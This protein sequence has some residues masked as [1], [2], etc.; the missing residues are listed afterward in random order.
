MLTSCDPSRQ[1]KC[2]KTFIL[3]E[4]IKNVVKDLALAY[5]T[6]KLN[7]VFLTRCL[8]TFREPDAFRNR[9][10]MIRTVTP[11]TV[12][13]HQLKILFSQSARSY[14]SFRD[15]GA[16]MRYWTGGRVHLVLGI[17]IHEATWRS[18]T[19]R[20]GLMFLNYLDRGLLHLY[21]LPKYAW[22]LK[23]AWG[24]T[25]R[26]CYRLATNSEQEIPILNRISFY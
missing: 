4:S 24:V 16:R 8:C 1:Q 14:S 23:Y 13:R 26:L 20:R 18:V 22:K 2:S 17:I 15:K 12:D 21:L 19:G 9:T 25:Y 6:E 10:S 3:V 11:S 5:G 7:F